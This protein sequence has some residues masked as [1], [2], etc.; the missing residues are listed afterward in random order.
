MAPL[1][2]R[3]VVADRWSICWLWNFP[4]KP[5]SPP[6]F[7]NRS[8]PS[9]WNS[10]FKASG[11]DLCRP[12]PLF[13]PAIVDLAVF[14]PFQTL[15][16]VNHWQTFFCSYFLNNYL[17]KIWY[18]NKWRQW[19]FQSIPFF[20]TI[21]SFSP[22]FYW[23]F[24]SADRSFFVYQCILVCFSLSCSRYSLKLWK[25]SLFSAKTRGNPPF[26]VEN[27]VDIVC[28][29]LWNR[30]T[31]CINLF[32]RRKFNIQNTLS[33]AGKTDCIQLISGKILFAGW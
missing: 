18:N 19:C 3:G 31:I 13:C 20:L 1:I 16:A 33:T 27:S 7:W 15:F 2:P 21:F 4:I 25:T 28:N 5:L 9:C 23:R 26:I 12:E 24:A 6:L 22:S 10:F 8:A 30:F 29:S 14:F 11:L 32:N 17:R